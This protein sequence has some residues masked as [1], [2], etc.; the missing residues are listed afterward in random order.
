MKIKGPFSSISIGPCSCIRLRRV[1]DDR[2]EGPGTIS[3]V[4]TNTDNNWHSAC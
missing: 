3:A 4:L 1:T 2:L